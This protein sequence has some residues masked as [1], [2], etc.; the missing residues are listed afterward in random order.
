MRGDEVVIVDWDSICL[1]PAAF[2]HA[3][4]LP[5]AERYGGDHAA[6][7]DFADGYGAEPNLPS[8]GRSA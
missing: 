8:T 3:A 5:W 4:L 7:P 6:Y 1:A 2:D